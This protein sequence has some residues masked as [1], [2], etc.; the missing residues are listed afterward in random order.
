MEGYGKRYPL[1]TY[2]LIAVMVVSGP[3]GNV[4]LSRG[5]KA[6]GEP[7]VWPVAA[8]GQTAV[9]IFSTPSIWMGIGSLLVFFVANMLVLTEA[10]Y[11]FVQPAGSLAYGVVAVLGIVMLGEHVSVLRWVGIAVICLGVIVVGR[12]EANTTSLSAR[13]KAE[14]GAAGSGKVKAEASAEAGTTSIEAET[15]A[16]AEG[17]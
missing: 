1:R 12:G 14:A 5:M 8:L 3:L 16:K 4:L 6:V 9:E 10:D 7:A 2:L 17:R 15:E 13:S 11:S